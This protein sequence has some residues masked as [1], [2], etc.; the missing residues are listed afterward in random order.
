MHNQVMES[1]WSQKECLIS[2]KSAREE[3][4][5]TQAE[6]NQGINCGI[7]HYRVNYAQGNS[8]LCLIR[9]EVEALVKKHG[10][11]HLKQKT[12]QTE[13][14]QIDKELRLLEKQLQTL[15]KRRVELLTHFAKSH[16]S[17]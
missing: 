4:G 11:D 2:D 16:H 14:S 13:L 15:Q 9:S 3:F 6:I 7:L 1:I 17:Q 10:G 8:F 12:L 5:I